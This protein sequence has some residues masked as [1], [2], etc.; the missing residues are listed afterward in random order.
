LCDVTSGQAVSRIPRLQISILY[1]QEFGKC[2][3]LHSCLRKRFS[4]AAENIEH[5]M[6][7]STQTMSVKSLSLPSY[8][9]C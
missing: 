9:D 5:G 8:C 1:V 3:M 2:F 6:L 4:I 7:L